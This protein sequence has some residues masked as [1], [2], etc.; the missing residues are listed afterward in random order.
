MSA[1]FQVLLGQAVLHSPAQG[2]WTY[3]EGTPEN[4]QTYRL[5][6]ARRMAICWR[7][8]AISSFQGLHRR[9]FFPAGLIG[10]S[11]RRRKAKRYSAP[12]VGGL[13]IGQIGDVGVL[14]PGRRQ[15]GNRV[16]Q[17]IGV[18]DPEMQAAGGVSFGHA[19][20]IPSWN[21]SPIFRPRNDPGRRMIGASGNA[22]EDRGGTCVTLAA[23]CGQQVADSVI[24]VSV[25]LVV[26][27]VP[28]IGIL[29]VH[30]HAAE[31][32]V[33]GYLAQ[34]AK[35]GRHRPRVA[36]GKQRLRRRPFRVFIEVAGRKFSVTPALRS[37][38]RLARAASSQAWSS[39]PRRSAR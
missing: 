13:G 24:G 19:L 11:A 37:A 23:S 33:P 6:A 38:L 26:N 31:A 16:V 25:N 9:K 2:V 34:G 28:K 4:D 20:N 14:K 35:L 39:A 8:S 7:N 27:R 30:T 5:D 17:A 3:H 36:V 1:P 10:A 32:Q 29:D 12:V 15:C 22:P 21:A 18:F